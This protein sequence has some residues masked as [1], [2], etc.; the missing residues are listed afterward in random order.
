MYRRVALLLLSLMS[1]AILADVAS[2]VPRWRRRRNTN[3]SQPHYSGWVQIAAKHDESSIEY[4]PLSVY[5]SYDRANAVEEAFEDRIQIFIEAWDANLLEETADLVAE[6][7]VMDV[8]DSSTTHVRYIPIQ[9]VDVEDGDY[10]LAK[11]E[12]VNEAEQDPVIQPA[13][14]YRVFINL[15]R[16][17]DEYGAASAIGRLPGAYYVATS[18]SSVVEQARHQIVMKTFREWYYT[19]RGWNRNATYPMDCHAYYRWA[20]GACTVGSTDGW[21][22]IGQLF[23]SGYHGA[24]NIPELIKEGPIHGD[25]VRVPGHTFMVLGYDDK[26]G[27]VWT[28]EAN[29]GHT[30]E[31]AQRQIGSG[32]SVGHLAAADIDHSL[33]HVSTETAENSDMADDMAP[34]AD[35]ADDMMAR[36]ATD[37]EAASD[38]AVQ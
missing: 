19:E 3:Y 14:V 16:K 24:G 28:M 35:D 37:S 1:I 33:F 21:A 8:S 2:A 20:T 5:C 26:T 6:V 32:W 4:S 12:V 36:N 29:F 15:H 27:H 10:K 38:T 9:L 7:K 11:L 17:S 25:Y 34:N 30:I 23:L 22:N 13:K 31:V 18:G